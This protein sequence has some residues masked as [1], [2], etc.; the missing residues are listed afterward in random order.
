MQARGDNLFS[1]LKAFTSSSKLRNAQERKAL[2]ETSNDYK[3]ERAIFFDYLSWF[4]VLE[5]FMIFICF[6]YAI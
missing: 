3:D 2:K 6:L 5:N 1:L 4:M